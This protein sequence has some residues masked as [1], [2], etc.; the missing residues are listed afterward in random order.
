[1]KQHEPESWIDLRRMPPGRRQVC[2]QQVKEHLP[3]DANALR[4]QCDE[5]ITAES[6]QLALMLKFKGD[7][8]DDTNRVWPRAVIDLDVALDRHVGGLQDFIATMVRIFGGKPAGEVWVK[9]MQATFPAGATYYTG[10]VYVEESA[11]VA[12]LLA[13]LAKP[14]WASVTAEGIMRDTIAM[15]AEVHGQYAEAVTKFVQ[16]ERVNWDSVKDQDLANHRRLCVLVA[17]IV[18]TFAADG[19]TRQ[20]L[21]A[22]VARQDQEVY[23]ALRD[24]RRV[25]DVDPNTGEPISPVVVT[26]DPV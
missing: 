20:R 4:S 26:P 2:F 19:A 15:L 11:R 12:T 8:A 24:R 6:Q 25:L 22:P 9:L 7:Q 10:Q 1:M 23:E 18:S 21:L 16:L 13:E 5:G 14:A 3:P 17:G